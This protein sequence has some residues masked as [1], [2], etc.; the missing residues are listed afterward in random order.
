[1]Q[2]RQNQIPGNNTIPVQGF[3]KC[4]TWLI[5][6][7]REA[8]NYNCTLCGKPEDEV[9]NLTAH[10]IIRGH[11]GGLYTVWPLMKKGNNVKIVCQE[12]HKTLHSS[13]FNR[14]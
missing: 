11:K 8:V 4:P 12:C 3:I 7:Y 1:M 5:N 9:G 6:K 13:E 10:R 14:K 2:N